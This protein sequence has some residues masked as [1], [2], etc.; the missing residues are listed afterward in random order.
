VPVITLLVAGDM[1]P[2]AATSLPLPGPA[3]TIGAVSDS[4]HSAKT[5][6]LSPGVDGA[7][8]MLEL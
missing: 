6:S 4:S 3:H 7:P 1:A 5:C 2:S 8:F